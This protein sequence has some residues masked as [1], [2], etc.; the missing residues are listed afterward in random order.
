MQASDITHAG[1]SRGASQQQAWAAGGRDAAL[2]SSPQ[3]SAEE[4][5]QLEGERGLSSCEEKAGED[6][7][8][9]AH[10]YAERMH[11]DA[12]PLHS[13]GHLAA[14]LCKARQDVSLPV[15]RERLGICCS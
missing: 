11:A 12:G 8:A 14:A 5:T 15:E 3:P 2:K 4:G 1:L 7:W 10:T 13:R 6:P 9:S